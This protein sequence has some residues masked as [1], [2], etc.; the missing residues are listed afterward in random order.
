[1]IPQAYNQQNPECGHVTDKP[2]SFISFSRGKKEREPKLR[3]LRN[4][5]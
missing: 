4:Q 2:R 3:D 5:T 1:M